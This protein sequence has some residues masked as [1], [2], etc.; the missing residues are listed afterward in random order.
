MQ[1]AAP[2]WK[3][4]MWWR[5]SHHIGINWHHSIG[6]SDQ[7]CASCRWCAGSSKIYLH[8]KS[9]ATCVMQSAPPCGA[10]CTSQSVP[11]HPGV[12][13]GLVHSL[14]AAFGWDWSCWVMH[15][16]AQDPYWEIE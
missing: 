14:E 8:S 16:P 2:T 5:D 13:W 4:L 9:G 11:Y 3:V 1:H 7:G 12:H 10:A 15:S 6:N